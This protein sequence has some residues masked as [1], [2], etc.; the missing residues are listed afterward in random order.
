MVR[1]AGGWRAAWVMSSVLLGLSPALV[2]AEE[3]KDSGWTGGVGASLSAQTGTT[4]S[5]V[6]SIDANGDRVW[7]RDE[8]GLRL[9]ATFGQTRSIGDD[10]GD[11][12]TQNSQ[13]L[14]GE[15]KRTVHRRFFWGSNSELSRDTVQN[16]EVRVALSSGP[17]FRLWTGTDEAKQHFDV[18][19]GFGYRFE[20]YNVTSGRPDRD[21]YDPD[22][23]ADVVANFEFKDMFLEDSIEFTHIG[24]VKMPA[25][26]VEAF[27]VSTELIFGVPLTAT[28]SL[29]ASFLAE[30]QNTVPDKTNKMTTRSNLGLSYKF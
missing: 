15:W 5:F 17:G 26:D 28:W 9:N 25:N 30:Y 19:G 6:G 20:L 1:L 2:Q 29:R 11:K 24:S 14:L 4:D 23:F 22:H 27:L 10:G 12:V 16:R 21:N 18:S 7:G 8:V 3:A 13:S